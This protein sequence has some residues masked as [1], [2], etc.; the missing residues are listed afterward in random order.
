MISPPFSFTSGCCAGTRWS[1]ADA[2]GG[3]AVVRTVAPGF[4]R[5]NAN[6]YG[7]ESPLQRAK[8][9]PREPFFRP[10]KRAHENAPSKTPSSK[11]G[12]TFLMTATPPSHTAT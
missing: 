4:N 6:Q 8:E 7:F 12:A 2:F 5:G 9:R 1:I 11:L 10:L 3:E